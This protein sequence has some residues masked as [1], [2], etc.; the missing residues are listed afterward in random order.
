MEK[1]YKII[2]IVFVFL[3]LAVLGSYIYLSLTGGEIIGSN[4]SG[5]VRKVT[6]S[7]SL[8]PE[9]K[10]AVVSGMH[11]RE[12]LSKEVMP[13]VSQLFTVNNN[14]M[15]VNYKVEVK[16]DPQDFYKGRSNG[17]QLVHDFIVPDVAKENFDLVIIAHDHEQGYGEGFYIATP[18]MDNKSLE[19]ADKV[20][21]KLPD[22][23][24]YT[25]NTTAP[26]ESTSV[27]KVDDPIVNT[28][29]ALF[30]YEIPE[31]LTEDEAFEQTYALLTAS[32]K[33][34]VG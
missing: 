23:R 13:T 25:R 1:K 6:Y 20:M 27:T 22:F 32:F 30:V 4:S 14:V 7:F 24:H 16:E 19:L 34:I 10:I 26:A 15:I 21:A 17:E 5:E 28:G 3:F 12:T 18:S 9:A 11:P 31:W 33:A 8:N 2:T 29:T